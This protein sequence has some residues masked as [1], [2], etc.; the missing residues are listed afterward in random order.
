MMAE[1]IP[2]LCNPK[3][4]EDPK[5]VRSFFVNAMREMNITFDPE[6]ADANAQRLQ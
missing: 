5:F 4:R 6:A 2:R 1:L 3:F